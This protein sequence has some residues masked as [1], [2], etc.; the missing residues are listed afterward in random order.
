[1]SLLLPSN[2]ILFFRID[3]Q[4]ILSFFDLFKGE[5][6]SGLKKAAA[7]GDSAAVQSILESI[8]DSITEALPKVEDPSQRKVLLSVLEQVIPKLNDVKS[9]QMDASELQQT[10]SSLDSGLREVLDLVFGI[11]GGLTGAATKGLKGLTNSLG[12]GDGLST[13]IK[14]TVQGAADG[15]G[16]GFL[17]GVSTLL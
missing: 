8:V 4:Y 9:K 17:E 11:L 14:E 5:V 6:M 1:M 10:V 16:E 7:N 2:S 13:A 3:L 15:G 12:G